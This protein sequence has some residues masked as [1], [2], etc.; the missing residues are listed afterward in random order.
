MNNQLRRRLGIWQVLLGLVFAATPGCQTM[1]GPFTDELAHQPPPST[2]S[3]DAARATSVER[4]VTV[5]A[6]EKTERSAIDG[7]VL[8]GP[9]YFEDPLEDVS[10]DDGVFA[11]SGMDYLTLL[12][13]TGRFLANMAF[14]PVSALVTPPWQ[15]MVSDG[16]SEPRGLYELRDAAV[17]SPPIETGDAHGAEESVNKH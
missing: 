16:I 3:A 5:R 15:W 2:P 11:L 14:I 4:R 8:H 9:L 1:R 7:A 17:W 13:S 10:E 6:H 12:G